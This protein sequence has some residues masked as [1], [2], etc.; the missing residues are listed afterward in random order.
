MKINRLLLSEKVE[1]VFYGSEKGNQ[2]EKN[3]P[4]SCEQWPRLKTAAF[5]ALLKEFIPGTNAYLFARILDRVRFCKATKEND[6]ILEHHLLVVLFQ[7]LVCFKS[8]C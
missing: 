6:P 4:N 3:H 1:I 8:T 7:I 2:G 5:H